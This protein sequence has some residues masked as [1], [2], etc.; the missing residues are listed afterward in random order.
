MAAGASNLDEAGEVE[1]QTRLAKDGVQLTW[2]GS[3]TAYK[4]LRSRRGP[5]GFED[6][7][8]T[9]V[10][11]RSWTDHEAATGLVYYRVVPV[12]EPCRT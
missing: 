6:P 2:D 3:G 5:Q 11:G 7:E 10:C 9:V 4:V 1:V 12:G 8:V